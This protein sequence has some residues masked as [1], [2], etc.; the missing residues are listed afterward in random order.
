MG[1]FFFGL[2]KAF[3][4]QVREDEDGNTQEM[5]ILRYNPPDSVRSAGLVRDGPTC[6][7]RYLEEEMATHSSVL[8]G[9][10]PWTEEP[11]GLRSMGSQEWGVTDRLSTKLASRNTLPMYLSI[12][13]TVGS[14]Q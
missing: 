11:G 9:R 3:T 14:P 1:F 5:S 8:A 2:R 7:G 13:N 4:M 6:K 10:P 12:C